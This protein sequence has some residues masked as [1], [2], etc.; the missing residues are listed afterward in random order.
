[1][2]RDVFDR[3]RDGI[4]VGFVVGFMYQSPEGSK[5]ALNAWRDDSAK[6]C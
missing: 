2:H 3:T 6:Q 1:M 4:L 5:D